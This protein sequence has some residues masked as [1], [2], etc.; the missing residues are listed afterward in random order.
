M[1]SGTSELGTQLGDA[2]CHHL[3]QL[4]AVGVAE[5]DPVGARLGGGHDG[6]QGIRRVEA[7]AVEEV[8]GVVDHLA[9]ELLEAGRRSRSIIRRFSA[10]VV[11]STRSTCSVELLPTSVTTGV[12]AST[13]A[14]MLGSSSQA[15][16]GAAGAAEGRDPRGRERQ[17]ARI[18]RKNSAS[19]GLEPGQP[20]S[21]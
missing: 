13:S 15:D 3:G 2:G 19:L 5:H 14:R 12:S 4:P 21:M 9:A 1:P 20:P 18:R 10:R 16:P 7:P 17:L 11:S 6:L 8:L